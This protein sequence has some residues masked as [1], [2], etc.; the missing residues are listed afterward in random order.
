[1]EILSFNL[2]EITMA[3]EIKSRKGIVSKAP[4]ELYMVFADMRNFVQFLPEDKKE[5]VE[6]DYDWIHAQVQGFN[7]GVKVTDRV[8]YSKICYAD[9]GAP[10]KFGLTLH[11]E[12]AHDPYKTDFQIVV[13]A[14]LNFMMKALLGGKIKEALDKVVDALVAMSEGRMPEGVDPSM[15]GK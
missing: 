10:F 1:V 11:F 13:D 9:D 8:P 6:A 3:V 2:D 4:Y 5:G 12:P 14:D 15:F 7:I